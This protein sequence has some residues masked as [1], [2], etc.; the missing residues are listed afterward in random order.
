LEVGE[1]EEAPVLGDASLLRQLVMILLDN[2]IKFTPSGGRVR[3][4]VQRS[5]SAVSVVVSDN[6]VGITDDQLPHILERFYRGDPSRTREPGRDGNG[7]GGSDGAGLG[8]SIT[9]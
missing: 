9:R 7:Q 8:L 1:F 5:G 6:G 3:V 2:A 4:D